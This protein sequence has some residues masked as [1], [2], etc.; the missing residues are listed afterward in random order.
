MRAQFSLAKIQVDAQMKQ[1]SAVETVLA[2]R[3]MQCSDWG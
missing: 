1:R 2:A 3:S